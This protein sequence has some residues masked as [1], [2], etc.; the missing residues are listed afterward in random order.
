MHINYSQYLSIV[1]CTD[2]FY[3]MAYNMTLFFILSSQIKEILVLRV[4][5]ALMGEIV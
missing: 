5:A 4:Q 2:L 3:I 1:K